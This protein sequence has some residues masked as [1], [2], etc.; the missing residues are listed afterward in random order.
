MRLALLAHPRHPL[1]P[2]FDGGLEAHTA[3]T[4]RHLARLG[5]DVTV[6]AREGSDLEARDVGPRAGSVTVVPTLPVLPGPRPAP[7]ADGVQEQCQTPVN[8]TCW[9][10]AEPWT[11]PSDDV[12]DAAL[13]AACQ[14]VLGGGFDAVLNNSLSPVP[15]LLLEGLPMLTVLHTPATLP[16]VLAVLDRPGWRPSPLHRWASVSA[17]NAATW[18]HRIPGIDVVHNGI[19]T[20]LW[21]SASEP[22]PG[23]AVWVGRITEEKGLHMAIEAAR[24]AGMELHFAGPIADHDYVER[25]VMPLLGED[26]V[27]R[28]HLDHAEVAAL[29]GEGEVCLVTPLWAE[30]FGLTAVEAMAVGTPVA[31]VL[32]GAMAEVVAPQAGALAEHHTAAA[33]TA[34]VHTA[35][36]RSRTA[37]R[38]WGQTFSATAM[39]ESYDALLRQAIQR[40]TSAAEMRVDRGPGP[41]PGRGLGPNGPTPNRSGQAHRYRSE[42]PWGTV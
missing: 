32:T 34:A 25:M 35:R 17:A 18:S 19:E 12:M 15:L 7:E 29:M 24:G 5:H 42:R 36:T 8:G 21:Q 39:A 20:E 3:L 14:Q 37:T 23:R 26:T 16:R 28:G 31:A 11:P 10:S 9:W 13:T 27:H 4:V 30:P 40:S 1:R 2:P 33:L 6:F 38:A 41:G 22:V